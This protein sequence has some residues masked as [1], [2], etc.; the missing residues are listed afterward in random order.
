MDK[1]RNRFEEAIRKQIRK[2]KI[3]Y[4][5]EGET[6]PFII[7]SHYTPDFILYTPL[8]KVYVECKGYFRPEDRRKM[9]AVKRLNPK[10]DLRILFQ[11]LTK[12]N[13]PWFIIK[14]YNASN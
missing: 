13:V 8:G 4:Q 3:V 14:D 10:M 5:Y 2:T 7:A 11:K 1:T 9:V 12:Q 6:I